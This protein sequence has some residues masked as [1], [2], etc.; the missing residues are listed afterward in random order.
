MGIW[1]RIFLTVGILWISY[2]KYMKEHIF[3][4]PVEDDT[5]GLLFQRIWGISVVLG[6][7]LSLVWLPFI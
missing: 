3:N 4:F 2:D 5:M 7:L 6:V 1:F